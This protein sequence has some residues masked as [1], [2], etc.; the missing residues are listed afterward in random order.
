ME[1]KRFASIDIGTVT[2]RLLIADID[3]GGLHELYRHTAIT[4][5]GEGVDA[6]G[7]LS[8]AA[9]KRVDDQIA[10]YRTDIDRFSADGHPIEV[11]AMATS[12]SRDA[13]NSRDFVAML[14]RRGIELQIIPGEYEAK[15]SF[16]GASS[17]FHGQRLLVADIGGGSTELIAGVG[18]E[19]PYFKHSYNIGCRRVTERFLH[20]DPPRKDEMRAAIEWFRPQFKR[21]FDRLAA[22]HFDIQRIVAVAGTA[23]SVV[24]ID[25]AME[26]Y[27]SARVDGSVVTEATLEEVFRNLASLTCEQRMQVT[28]LQPG[29]AP[30]IVAGTLILRELLRLTGAR[31]FTASES[32]ILQGMM[33]DA[34]R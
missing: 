17:R 10:A 9:M 21:F 12:A 5:L 32:D 4:N 31:S 2:C 22:E 25:Q 15:L 18:G 30:V 16:L 14:A 8:Q 23:T 34:V 1:S 33:L 3:D 29:R 27:D 11:L 6:S 24:S 7:V 13:E 20:S 19:T 28:G 26:V